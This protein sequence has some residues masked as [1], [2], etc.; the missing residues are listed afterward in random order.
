MHFISF[1]IVSS[2]PEWNSLVNIRTNNL[3]LHVLFSII[4]HYSQSFFSVLYLSTIF[5]VLQILYSPSFP[6]APIHFL[7]FFISP[8]YCHS[9]TFVFYHSHSFFAVVYHSPLFPF[10]WIICFPS[11]LI[12]PIHSFLFSIIP[13]YSQSFKSSV[14]HHLSLLSFILFCSLSFH[15]HSQSFEFSVDH[16]SSLFPF[17]PFCS[18]S[19]PVISI[20]SLFFCHS[21]LIPFIQFCSLSL[22]IFPIHSLLLSI[23]CSS[24]FLLFPF[25]SV[26][27]I[28]IYPFSPF[29]S[30]SYIFIGRCGCCSWCSQW[31]IQ[32]WKPMAH[33]GSLHEGSTSQPS[34]RFDWA[35]QS[36]LDSKFWWKCR[37]VTCTLH[38]SLYY[39]ELSCWIAVTMLPCWC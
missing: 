4:S 35:W 36:S 14:L 11:F 7:L 9:F 29:C 26:S 5:T 2:V 20:H 33:N 32:A 30:L 37:L 18:P 38:A 23:H 39:E 25:C 19:F 28:I 21:S 6:I 24:L 27:F 3:N 22:L 10:I 1:L 17:N 34:C 15:I 31:G 16:H 12:T 8:D 13:H